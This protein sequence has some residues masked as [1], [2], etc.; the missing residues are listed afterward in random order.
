MSMRHWRN[1]LKEGR[2]AGCPDTT[3]ST[4]NLTWTELDSKP[5]LSGE[6]PATNHVSHDDINF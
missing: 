2:G 1:V 4:I 6:T 3:L 5:H